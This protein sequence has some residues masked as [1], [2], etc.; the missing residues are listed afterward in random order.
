MSNSQRAKM[1]GGI[2]Y[3]IGNEAAERFSY[4]GMKAILVVFMTDYLR[5]SEVHA[6]EWLHSFGSAVYAFPIIGAIVADVFWG[7]YKTILTLSVVYCLGHF[8]LAI[9]EDQFGLALGLTLIAI[10]SGGIKPCVSAHVG[11]QFNESNKTLISK[12]FSFFYLA[13]NLGAFVS[14]LLTPILLQFAG[15][16][17]AFG[18]PGL[19]MF[20]A[21]I[22][23]W[24]GRHD[25]VHIPPFGKGFLKMLSSKEGLTAIG[26]LAIIYIFISVFWSLFDQTASTWV[27]QAKSKFLD[28]NIDI[29]GLNFELLPSQIQAANP[30]FVLMLVPV[31]TFLVYPLL[32]KVIPM[33]PLNRI[34]VGMF[35]A[36]LSFV[37][38]GWVEGFIFVGEYKSIGWQVLA[39]FILTAAEVMISITAL[40]FSYTQ[41][42]N[43]MK[44]FIMGLYLLS[45]SLGNFITVGVNSWMN[46]GRNVQSIELG[47]ETRVHLSSTE[48]LEVGHK[49][50]VEEL[51]SIQVLQKEDT[52]H[53]GGTYLVGSI[54]GNSIAL[55]DIN[56]VPVSTLQNSNFDESVELSSYKLNGAAYFYFFAGLMAVT[57]LLFFFVAFNY[58]EKEYIQQ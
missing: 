44:S 55:W 40:E 12:I 1:P 45:V 2:P 58:K 14:T 34:L 49:I 39:Y 22:V 3:I 53:L 13:I 46:E 15:P 7:K 42:P 57:G 25:F 11:D 32:N 5:M 41:A 26:R 6:T 51:K 21:T 43:E 29:L 28:K 38:V 31:F 19:L 18:I 20:I 48:G 30:I 9:R 16:G 47:E 37:I 33:K 4:Y 50:G 8:V 27:I 35:I 56:R 23:F 17:W 10:G 24:L 36:A 54:E 52:V